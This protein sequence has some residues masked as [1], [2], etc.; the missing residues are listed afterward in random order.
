MD[1]TIDVELDH[2]CAVLVIEL[3]KFL[4]HCGRTGDN[5]G[6][7]CFGEFEDL[8]QN[9]ILLF[10]NFINLV[11]GDELTVVELKILSLVPVRE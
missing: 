9:H 6:P 2:I 4:L 8:S 1:H 11:N 10:E 5:I 7:A 3:H